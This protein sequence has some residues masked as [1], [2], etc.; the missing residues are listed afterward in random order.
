ML[1]ARVW[2]QNLAR[3]ARGVFERKTQQRDTKRHQ[4]NAV[5]VCR[6]LRRCCQ[7]DLHPQFFAGVDEAMLHSSEM[8][9]RC[10]IW[11]G[12]TSRFARCSQSSSWRKL[13]KG[14]NGT[15]AVFEA[16]T[17]HAMEVEQD[18]AWL[19]ERERMVVEVERQCVC[20]EE[21]AERA[22]RAYLDRSMRVLLEELAMRPGHVLCAAQ[23]LDVTGLL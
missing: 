7:D 13:S 23:V 2:F 4:R 5:P 17:S 6:P 20:D 8:S 14:R 11:S 18:Q 15:E 16:K 19:N 3:N 9:L 22:S 1:Q 21:L 10:S 12:R